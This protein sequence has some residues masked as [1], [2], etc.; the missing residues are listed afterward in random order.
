MALFCSA[1]GHRRGCYHLEV[2][3]QVNVHKW[4][5]GLSCSEC[6]STYIMSIS[7]QFL[8]CY[9]HSYISFLHGKQLSYQVHFIQHPLIQIIQK[10]WGHHKYGWGEHDAKLYSPSCHQLCYFSDSS[11]YSL[12]I[13]SKWWIFLLVMKRLNI[14][15]TIASSY[16]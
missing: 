8:F 10:T 14:F 4:C 11:I 12:C 7:Y 16:D 6:N 5:C 3:T 2:F 1:A 13:N 15:F 9:V